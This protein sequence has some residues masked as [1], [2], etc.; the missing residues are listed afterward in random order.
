M[1]QL[2]SIIKNH[3]EPPTPNKI[4]IASA[5]RQLDWKAKAENLQKLKKSSKNITV[6]RTGGI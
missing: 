6:P 1:Y 3:D 4:D 2:F 5:K